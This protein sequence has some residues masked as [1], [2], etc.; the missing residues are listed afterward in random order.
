MRVSHIMITQDILITYLFYHKSCLSTQD[1]L[2]N[3]ISDS[4]RCKKNKNKIN[5][6][7]KLIDLQEIFYF[8]ILVMCDNYNS[9]Y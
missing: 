9:N 5:K 4:N 2:S 8:N 6:T 7:I 1:T 3:D